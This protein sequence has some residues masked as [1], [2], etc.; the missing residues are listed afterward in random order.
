MKTWIMKCLAFL[1]SLCLLM[2]AAGCASVKVDRKINRKEDKTASEKDEKEQDEEEN[3]TED[4]GDKDIHLEQ[5][6]PQLDMETAEGLIARFNVYANFGVCSNFGDA[7]DRELTDEILLS[8]GYN[9]QYLEVYSVQEVSCCSSLEE[10]NTHIR[11]YLSDSIVDTICNWECNPVE[12]E[13]KLYS[14]AAAMGYGGFY[15]KGE[16]VQESDT[17]ASV[18]LGYDYEEEVH[19]AV[20]VYSDS[21][22]RLSEIVM[23]V[24]E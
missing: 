15:I 8:A 19:M 9:R 14:V 12:Y 18:A 6:I 4:E 16:L 11:E 13:G 1:L 2:A 22:W 7:V 24:L 17:V 10:C 3:I 5:E 23:P 20:F 21:R